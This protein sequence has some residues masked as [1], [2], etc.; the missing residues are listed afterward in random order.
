MALRGVPWA[1]GGGAHNPVEG[2]RLSLYAATQGA[3]GVVRPTDMLVTALPVP[4][5]A[6]RIRRGAA[7]MP[8]DY[9]GAGAEAYAI[10]ETSYTDVPVPATGSSGGATR[11][12]IGRVAD[13]QFAGDAPAS[14]EDGPYSSYEWLTTNPEVSPP[15]YPWAPLARI[16]QPASTATITQSMITDIRQL[17]QPRSQRVLHARPRV[18]DDSTGNAILLNGL[19][20]NGGEYFPGGA[21]SPNTFTVDAPEWATRMI[22][23]A[24]W[25]AVR[26]QAN[27]NPHGRYWVEFGDEYRDHGWNNN[28]QWEFGTQL[29]QFDSPGASNNTM[30]TNWILGDSV[31]LAPKL[32]GKRVTFAFKAG[33]NLTAS[34]GH[35]SMDSLGG[36]IMEVTFVEDALDAHTVV[37]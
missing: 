8:N 10:E 31:A 25:L 12:L 7:V 2:A 21:G 18:M 5:G 23:R 9:A 28:R 32:R 30:R 16:N 13:P 6:V 20:E 4:G 27:T 17:A 19:V 29:F 3:R 22:I 15:S 26:Y 1:I 24:D 14:V 35:V 34:R 36:L 37:T 11:Y 33:V